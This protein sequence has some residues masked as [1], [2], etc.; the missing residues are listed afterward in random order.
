M[1]LFNRIKNVINFERCN[2]CAQDNHRSNFAQHLGTNNPLFKTVD[3]VRC[4][5][6][7]LVIDSG[8]IFS[9]HMFTGAHQGSFLIIEN[10]STAGKSSVTGDW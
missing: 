3:K 5:A 10:T 8:P 1:K 6:G 9:D 4:G 2:V 7:K